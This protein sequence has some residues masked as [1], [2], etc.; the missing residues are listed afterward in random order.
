MVDVKYNSDYCDKIRN[1]I[2]YRQIIG[3]FPNSNNGIW[4]DPDQI[5]DPISICENIKRLSTDDYFG[6]ISRKYLTYFENVNINTYFKSKEDTT[7]IPYYLFTLRTKIQEV[8]NVTNKEY[9]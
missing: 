9:I 8:I 2:L 3:T 1:L 6:L 7:D 4:V 5:I